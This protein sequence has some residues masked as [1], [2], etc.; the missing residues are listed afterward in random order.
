M[1]A[2]M[3][4]MTR[5]ERSVPQRCLRPAQAPAD[6]A[7]ERY[8]PLSLSKGPRHSSPFMIHSSHSL[9]RE[10]IGESFPPLI[11][12]SAGAFDQLRHRRCHAPETSA[13]ELVEG[14]GGTRG[15]AGASDRLRHRFAS[16]L[17]PLAYT[18]PE[19]LEGAGVSSLRSP[20]RQP[21]S[22]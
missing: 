9:Y 20:P 19:L 4:M 8:R 1:M 13:P 3:A 16:R 14:A 5:P 2:M 21:K 11:P 12:V 10:V 7:R 17:L 18:A 22:P 15:H 6:V